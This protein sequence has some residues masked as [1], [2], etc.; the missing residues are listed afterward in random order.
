M[1]SDRLSPDQ[2]TTLRTQRL[3]R[4]FAPVYDAVSVPFSLWRWRKWQRR[5]LPH[6]RGRVL[7]V[8][9]GTGALLER[10]LARGEVVGLDLSREMLARA[11]RRQRSRGLPAPLVCG[12]A[13]HLPFRDGAFESVVSTFVINAVPNL[14]DALREMLRVLRVGGSLAFICVGESER[15]GRATRWAA[16][17]WRREG[18]IIR[19]EVGALRQLGVE[20]VREDF[21]PFGTVH[22]I[23]A[24][25]PGAERATG[26]P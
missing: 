4:R 2:E 12:D 7:E 21:G 22:L 17:V 26:T 6:A 15:G 13:Q 8:G 25:K 5:V 20:C 23:T 11:V 14:Q 9:C 3:Y 18:D 19:D 10:L 16:A 1:R 24:V